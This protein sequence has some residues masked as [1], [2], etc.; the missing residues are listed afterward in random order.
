M[1]DYWGDEEQP[2]C[3]ILER[4][5][6][7]NLSKKK[8]LR[9]FVTAVFHWRSVSIFFLVFFLSLSGIPAAGSG[10]VQKNCGKNFG[11]GTEHQN[12]MQF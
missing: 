11:H 6:M 4:W 7:V 12:C 8:T 3:L 9:F 5:S 1:S 10:L 2:V